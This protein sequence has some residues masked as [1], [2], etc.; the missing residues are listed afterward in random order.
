MTTLT[1]MLVAYEQ[2]KSPEKN[3][4]FHVVEENMTDPPSH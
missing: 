4:L 1:Q 3:R 2:L